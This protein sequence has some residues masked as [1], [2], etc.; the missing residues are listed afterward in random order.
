MEAADFLATPSPGP[1]SPTSG[2]VHIMQANALTT[3]RYEMSACEMDI[4]FYL[5]S[6]LS[7]HDKLGTV[8]LLRVQELEL[9]TG[10]RWNYQRLFEST[11]QLRSRGYVIAGQK[12]DERTGHI[13][14]TILQ[15]GLLA[16]AQYVKGEGVIELEISE[17]VRP[18]LVDL[19]NNFTSY[20]LQAALLLNSKYAKRI[21][22]LCSQWK[23]IGETKSY[24]LDEFKIMLHLKDPAGKEPEQYKMISNLQR[25]VL[26][27][28]VAQINEHTDLKISYELGKKGR[29]YHSIRFY[30]NKQTPHQ[31]PLAFELPPQDAKMQSAANNLNTLGIKD[32]ALVAQILGSEKL[33]TDLFEF[34]YKHKTNKI[35]ADKNPGGLFLKMHGLAG[36][37]PKTS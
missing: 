37:K 4:V 16:S 30:I 14:Q 32:P 12:E 23:D 8:Y 33:T 29:A 28:S 35:K 7:K 22:Q 13:K 19:K 1:A 10:R 18:Y 6:K 31:L 21:Y 17:K 9:L 5:L 36:F 27:A 2:P 20:R 24:T 15:V 34:M 26:D 11:E 3:A 25:V